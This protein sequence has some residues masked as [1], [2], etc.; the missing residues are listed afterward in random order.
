MASVLVGLLGSTSAGPMSRS[1]LGRLL[2]GTVAGVM[3]GSYVA[4]EVVPNQLVLQVGSGWGRGSVGRVC[5]DFGGGV[6]AECGHHSLLECKSVL[7]IHHTT[8]NHHPPPVHH[9]H[10][11]ETPASA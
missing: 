6:W 3:V 4:L 11:H 5:S 9:H 10:Q 1:V 7:V 2:F 8:A